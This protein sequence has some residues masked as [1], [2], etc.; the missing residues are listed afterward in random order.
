MSRKAFHERVA[1]QLIEQLK[2]GAASQLRHAYEAT[3]RDRSQRTTA[4]RSPQV[5]EPQKRARA[6]AL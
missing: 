3:L 1:E 4:E 5:R 6:R 2:A